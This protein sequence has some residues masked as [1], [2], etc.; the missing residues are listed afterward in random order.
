MKHQVICVWLG[1]HSS[2]DHFYDK[3]LAIDYTDEDHANSPFGQDALLTYY[4]EDFVESWW[5]NPLTLEF[6]DQQQE[7]LLHANY[8]FDDLRKVLVKLEL[9]N[10]NAITFMFGE[11]GVNGFNQELFSYEGRQ[12]AD[13]PTV[14]VFKK[15]YVLS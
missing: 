4:D 7:M 15:E 13:S 11:A 1:K 2:E 9:S 5:A 14:F 3:H 6:L 10:Y 12:Q 8:F